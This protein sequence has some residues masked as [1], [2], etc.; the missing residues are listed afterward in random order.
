MKIRN[1]EWFKVENKGNRRS[2][3]SIFDNIGGG[4]FSAGFTAKA[5]DKQLRDAGELDDIDV[6]INSNG[7]EA[8]EGFAVYNILKNHSAKVHVKIIGIAASIASVIAMAGDDIEI[9][10]NGFIMVH[11]PRA[12]DGGDAKRFRK[13]ADMLDKVNDNIVKSYVN[14]TGGKEED[15]RAMVEDETWMTA[16][17]AVEKGFA[18]SVSDK[19]KAVAFIGDRY[20]MFANLPALL[21]AQSNP[22]IVEEDEEGP[23]PEEENEMTPEEIQ[24]MINGAVQPLN[25]RISALT[26]ENA[27][28]TARVENNNRNTHAE[29]IEARVNN[30]ISTRRMVPQDREATLT[31]LNSVTPEQANAYLAAAE[32]RSPINGTDRLVREVTGSNGAR[33]TVSV[34]RAFT[35]PAAE[36]TDAL[37]TPSDRGLQAFAQI[38]EGVKSPDEFRAK[39]YAAYGEAPSIGIKQ[40]WEN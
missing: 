10:E 40:P 2:L 30:L 9:A 4:F 8:F 14:R 11:A 16:E 28:L 6:E 27:A 15:I 1:S 25:E 31:L 36:G 7:G 23:T 35:I 29:T 3:V 26:A 33:Q 18:D 21:V 32:K 19:V 34:D 20:G 22:E 12:F 24:A 37:I 39:A 13:T 17:E 38:S 5:L